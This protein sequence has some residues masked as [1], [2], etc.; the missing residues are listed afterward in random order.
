MTYTQDLVP[1][2]T[3]FVFLPPEHREIW[4]RCAFLSPCL[5]SPLSG[6]CT[7]QSRLVVLGMHSSAAVLA[8]P[9]A[10]LLVVTEAAI[11]VPMLSMA[12]LPT[13]M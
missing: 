5:C 8:K 2:T 7:A 13:I 4:E 3:V 6:E 12:I 1:Q 11:C 10:L 9:R